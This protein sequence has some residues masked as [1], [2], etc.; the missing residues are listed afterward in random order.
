VTDRDDGIRN[1]AD[2]WRALEEDWDSLLSIVANFIDFRSPAMDPP[3][4]PCSD[5][6]KVTGRTVLDELNH[7]KAKG[8]PEAGWALARYFNAAWGMASDAYAWGVPG[9][10]TLCDLCSEEWAIRP[11]EES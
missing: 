2:W 10:G 1:A 5:G 7:L 9:W 4:R 8:T 3:G 11:E 6:G